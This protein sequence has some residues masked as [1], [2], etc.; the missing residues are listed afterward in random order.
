MPSPRLFIG[1]SVERLTVAFIL[2]EALE[3]DC[4]STVW[5]QDI[6]RPT[7]YALLELIEATKT[8][9]FAAFILAQDDAVTIRGKAY[10]APRDNVIFELGLFVG[11]RGPDRCFLVAPRSSPDLHL[12]S[13]LLGL[14]PLTYQDDRADGNFL[15]ALGPAANKIRRA[16]RG[17]LPKPDR[18]TT[19]IAQWNG[20]ELQA[21][22]EHLRS[23][24]H[25]DPY[26]PSAVIDRDRLRQL[27]S[28]L[29]SVADGVLSGDLDDALARSTF[30]QPMRASWSWIATSL[31]PPNHVDDYWTPLPSL[32]VLLER[33]K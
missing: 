8:Q 32:A 33:W 15:A 16:M 22:R 30:E 20:P 24:V 17:A 23:G 13:D 9:D 3:Y 31:A 11:A 28:F 1:S 29:N 5:T 7:R 19:Y 26:D 27:F 25:L 14:T 10:A 21:V 2:Q 6:F 18:L 4:E 12:P